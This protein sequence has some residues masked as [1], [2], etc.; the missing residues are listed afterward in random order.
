[1]KIETETQI[2][3]I[4]D[5]IIT[6]FD[7]TDEDKSKRV[8][9]GKGGQNYELIKGLVDLIEEKKEE[10]K[11]QPKKRGRWKPDE[12]EGYYA[13]NSCDGEVEIS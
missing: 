7:K 2:F 11:S 13:I 6:I 12:Y 10:P 1:M 8:I 5:K 4:D 9:F 3:E